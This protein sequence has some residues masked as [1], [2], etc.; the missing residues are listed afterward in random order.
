M[1]T[2]MQ[3]KDCRGIFAATLTPLTGDERLDVG[4]YEKL[5]HKVLDEGQAGI[6]VAGTT[7]EGYALDDG[8]RVEICKQSAKIAQSRRKPGLVIAHVG[9]VPTKR[10]LALA[11]AAADAGCNAISAVPP[12]G[13]RYNYDEITAYYSDIANATPL[14]LIVYYIPALSGYDFSRPQLSRWM[15]MPKVL[16]IKF[17]S[18][19]MYR[20]ERLATLH[21]SKV[22]FSGHDEALLAGLVS[23]AKGSIG[24]T[25]NLMGR[26]ALKIF[27]AVQRRDM[28]TARKAQAAM[29]AFI[30]DMLAPGITWSRSH[31]LLVAEVLGWPSAMTPGPGFIPSEDTIKCMRASYEAAIA[32][33]E[34]LP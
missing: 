3:E 16:G 30:E 29:N 13:G 8:I 33:I 21:P 14:P 7:G 23:G 12:T 34:T 31:K 22:V 17:T 5:I 2:P 9:G 24:A 6:Y 19:D 25:Y 32:L 10:A 4:A 15:E 20:L 18:F 27:A 11:R 26:V 1:S 28:D